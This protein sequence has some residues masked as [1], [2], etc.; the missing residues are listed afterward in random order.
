MQAS[1]ARHF[2]GIAEWSLPAGGLF[3]WVR[4]R[5]GRDTMPLLDRALARNVAFMPGEPFFPRDAARSGAL[6]LNFSHSPPE[7]IERGVALLAEAIRGADGMEIAR[8]G[9]PRASG[10]GGR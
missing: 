7:K 9:A 4:L 5:D 2:E 10:T 1:L 8:K 3:F 6:R